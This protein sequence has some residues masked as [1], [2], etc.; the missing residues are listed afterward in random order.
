MDK[1]KS[2][3]TKEKILYTIEELMKQKDITD[4]NIRE[5]CKNAQISIGTFYM[6]F[7]CKEA[8]VLYCYRKADEIFESLELKEDAISNIEK[9]MDIYVHMVTLHDIRSIKQ[10]YICHIKYYD[11]YFFSE[12]R[13]VFIRLYE[14]IDKIILDINK[15]KNMAMKI[16]TMA[17]GLI[18]HVCCIDEANIHDNWYEKSISELM[19]YTKF[20]FIQKQAEDSDFNDNK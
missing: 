11:P 9:I 6:Y 12:E 18:Y 19:Q 1:K 15:S 10:L 8:A 2:E 20:L 14:E 7:P 3:R 17:R 13:P 5:I 16:L 4:I